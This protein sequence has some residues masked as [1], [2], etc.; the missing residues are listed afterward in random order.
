[1]KKN[2]KGGGNG[3]DFQLLVW[4]VKELRSCQSCTHKEKAEQPENQQ[5]FLD[6]L[7]DWVPRENCCPQ[8]GQIGWYNY[9]VLEQKPRSKQRLRP[10]TRVEK[11]KPLTGKLLEVQCG[12]VWDW[13]KS[14]GG[15]LVQPG[16]SLESYHS[17]LPSKKLRKLKKSTIPVGS[18]RE[19]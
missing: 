6:L 19:G 11:H 2:K 9:N 8:I 14:I 12:Q 5:L 4:H 13:K 10:R 18:I 7:K 3:G 1:M 15:F 16:R 17:A